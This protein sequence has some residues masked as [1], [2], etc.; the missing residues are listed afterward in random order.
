MR[1]A[2]KRDTI[3]LIQRTIQLSNNTGDFCNG[4]AVQATVNKSPDPNPVE[5]CVDGITNNCFQP[6]TIAETCFDTSDNRI[7]VRSRLE[8]RRGHFWMT[9]TSGQMKVQ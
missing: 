1:S 3:D 6:N 8:D 7:F 9:D 5:V 2:N 4:T